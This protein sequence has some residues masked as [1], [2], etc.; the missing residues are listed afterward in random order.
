MIPNDAA[1]RNE[2][3]N[4]KKSFIVQAPAGSGKTETLTQ[5]YLNLLAHVEAPEEIIALTFTNKAANEMQQRIYQSLL[6]AQNNPEPDEPHKKLTFKLAQQALL[7]DKHK[8]WQLLMSP[9]RLRIMTI[10]AFCQSLSKQLVFETDEAFN[11]EIS[12]TPELLY[13]QAIDD[14][15]N[16]THQQSPFYQDVHD[17][18]AHLDNDITR[19]KNLLSSMLARREQWLGI[20]LSSNLDDTDTIHSK[21]SKMIIESGFQALFAELQRRLSTLLNIDQNQFTLNEI[22]TFCDNEH[23]ETLIDQDSPI[24]WQRL[25]RMLFTNDNTFRKTFN[26]RQGLPAKDAKAKA[27]AQWLISYTQSFSDNSLLDITALVAEIRLYERLLLDDQEWQ[28]LSAIARIALRLVSYLK[29]VFKAR[30]LLDFNEVSLQALSALGNSEAPTDLMLYLDHQI[31]HLL[32]DEFQ[33]TSILQFKLLQM[34]TL[35]WQAND[36]KTLFIVGDPMQSI[37]RFRQAEVNQ[38]LDVKTHGINQVAL[39][40]L[41]LDCNFRSHK[42][43]VDWVNHHFCS[44]FPKEDDRNYGGISYAPATTLS[45]A[46][47]Q[48]AIDYRLFA[49]LTQEALFIADSI[50]AHLNK[51]TGHQVAILVRTRSHLK[52]LVPVLKA[53][54]VAVVENE[55]ETFYHQPMVMDLL[56]LC[57]LLNN[58]EQSIYWVSLLQSPLFGFSLNELQTIE[59]IEVNEQQAKKP[60]SFYAKLAVYLQMQQSHPHQQKAFYFLSWIK[61]NFFNGVRSTLIARLKI[62]WQAL[63]GFSIHNDH[64]LF[65]S[66]INLLQS[67][68]TDDKTAIAQ[69]DRFIA[70][71]KRKFVSSPSQS[72]VLIMTIHKSKGLEF[73]FVILPQLDKRGKADDTPLFL[74]DT[75][76]LSDGKDHLLLSPI[77]HS[78][79]KETP[80]LFKVIQS[81]QKKRAEYELQR[82]LY[83]AV[84]RAKSMLLFTAVNENSND[85]KT[86]NNSF[87]A[88]LAP[89]NLPWI[90]CEDADNDISAVSA[91]QEPKK[92]K[93]YYKVIKQIQNYSTTAVPNF[94]LD[95]TAV[96][97]DNADNADKTDKENDLNHP[98][99]NEL[100]INSD[101]QIGSALHQLFN[102]LSS[103][104]DN[105]NH[106]QNYFAL[107]LHQHAIAKAHHA[108]AYALA[109]EA[110]TNTIAQFPW[111]I[112]THG[113][114]EQ[115]ML[116]LNFGKTQKH[117]ADRIIIDNDQYHIIDYKFA[118][119]V[120]N[121][122]LE[123]FVSTQT[124]AYRAQLINY[125][126][127]IAR[128][129]RINPSDIK[130][131]LYFPLIPHL[132]AL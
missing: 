88:L 61:D 58:P 104:K 55:I 47:N 17:L 107:C 115:V 32:I 46:L 51:H 109:T 60:H 93:P 120:S 21:K 52:H 119:P 111:I 123:E 18:L 50:K 38:F 41:Q 71:L 2:A 127:L 75:V 27:Y 70:R 34:L 30:A 117:I 114:H 73:D 87:L 113:M 19:V 83:V 48:E 89:L 68:L 22:L 97:I 121:E 79:D 124:A 12:D 62:I 125:Q 99:L 110:I 56:C 25:I 108:R 105:I 90:T 10:D 49:D 57:A 74:H 77:K 118:T 100:V 5:R 33:D 132:Q 20:L 4:P 84:T 112:N 94:E 29:L 39:E 7:Q 86:V 80:P 9:K 8:E 53:Q 63:D 96:E 72:N 131:S 92:P 102:Y 54:G 67:H 101:R 91:D 69:F 81:M 36:G 3:L 128:Y 24:F 6:D 103:A 95:Q 64:A 15:I 26:A 1:A 37:Y 82:L 23:D 40:F 85:L 11:A 35:E 43:I 45:Q 76:R 78:W 98:D 126:K 28:I 106:W 16:D 66:F 116:H 31:K 129:F 65:A 13:E 42:S 130:L 14:F 122:S 44:I 59:Q